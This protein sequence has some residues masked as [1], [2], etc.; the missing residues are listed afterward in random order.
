MIR[1]R[2]LRQVTAMTFREFMRTPEA[3]FWTYGFPL[4]M[5]VVIGLA[6]MLSVILRRRKLSPGAA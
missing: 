4:L 1:W 3:V 2:V 5:T 6:L